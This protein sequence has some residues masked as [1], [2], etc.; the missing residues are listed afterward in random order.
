MPKLDVHWI[1]TKPPDAAE[2]ER[3][4]EDCAEEAIGFGAVKIR[5][6]GHGWWIEGARIGHVA[7]GMGSVPPDPGEPLDYRS[8]L[9]E[10]LRAKGK[11]VIGRDSMSGPLSS[12]E[13]EAMKS[14]ARDLARLDP[15]PEAGFDQQPVLDLLAELEPNRSQ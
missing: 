15:Q 8:H 9:V 4:I 10:A 13:I 2:W 12:A 3:I 11:Q 14:A 6:V 5:N 7:L 1:G